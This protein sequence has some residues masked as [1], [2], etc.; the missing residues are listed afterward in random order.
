[1]RSRRLGVHAS[2]PRRR[3]PVMVVGWV[4][5]RVQELRLEPSPVP[6]KPEPRLRDRG[7]VGRARDRRCR[8]IACAHVRCRRFGSVESC[9][10]G[11]NRAS[12]SFG[13]IA[14]ERVQFRSLPHRPGDPSVSILR[15]SQGRSHFT[16]VGRLEYADASPA[17]DVAGMLQVVTRIGWELFSTDV[18]SAVRVVIPG[19]V[20]SFGGIGCSARTSMRA[21]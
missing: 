4:A 5:D 18:A 16:L 19:G 10:A 13:V 12:R 2:D 6:R 9:L 14:G 7:L 15:A 21:I 8:W 1:M 11:T 17:D 3:R 20:A